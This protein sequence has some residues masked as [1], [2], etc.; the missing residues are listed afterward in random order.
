MEKI[1]E[2]QPQMKI[3]RQI[4]SDMRFL[5]RKVS[6]MEKELDEIYNSLHEVRPEYLKKLERIEKK[7]K[8]ISSEEFER[9][10]EK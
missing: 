3:L 5:K 6:F 2:L 1:K 8:F 7:G 4:E 10:L 9:Q